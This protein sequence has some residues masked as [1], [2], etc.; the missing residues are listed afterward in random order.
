LVN[1]LDA[2]S[3]ADSNPVSS[4]PAFSLSA[5]QTSFSVNVGDDATPTILINPTNGFDGE[6]SLS[7]SRN[8]DNFSINPVDIKI[9]TESILTLDTSSAGIYQITIDGTSGTLSDSLTIDLTV[10]N[11]NDSISSEVIVDKIEYTREG[12]QQ[13]D[14]HLIVSVF[15]VNDLNPPQPVAG[16]DVTISLTCDCSRIG[17]TGTVVSDSSGIAKFQLSNAKSGTYTTNVTHI[18]GEPVNFQYSQPSVKTKPS[19]NP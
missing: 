12:G 8:S 17:W 7:S 15:V 6:V 3:A 19:N 11:P 1:T 13:G 18:D 10:I 14:K 2:I 5:S 4:D 16:V 9:S